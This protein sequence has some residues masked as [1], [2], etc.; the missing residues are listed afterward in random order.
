MDLFNSADQYEGAIVSIQ[1]DEV[2]LEGEVVPQ[3]DGP[4]STPSMHG[5]VQS[6]NFPHRSPHNYYLS[7]LVPP[8]LSVILDSTETNRESDQSSEIILRLNSLLGTISVSKIDTYNDLLEI[9]AYHGP[10]SRR[11]A[12]S[13]MAKFWPKAAGHTS[14]S[15]PFCAPLQ[16]H[17][18]LSKHSHLHQFVPWHFNFNEDR[19]HL[20][21]MSH[22]NCR[23]CTNPLRGF[24]LICPF[25]MCAVHFDCYDYPEGNYQI[26]YSMAT[27]PTVQ[28][29]AMYRFSDLGTDILTG[30]TATSEN[31]DFRPVNW[32]TLC[33]CYA[34]QTPLWGWIAQGLRCR[35]CSVAVHM[36]CLDS[37]KHSHPCE[38]IIF[39]SMHMTI[40]WENLRNSCLAHF[41][42]L[43]GFTRDELDGCSRE[44]ISIYHA[45]FCTQ[46]QLLS[47][48]IAMGSI[49]VTEKGTDSLYNPSYEVTKFEL[50]QFTNWCDQLLLN[51]LPCSLLTQQFLR[52]N[53]VHRLD[54]SLMHEW[55]YLE[56]ISSNLKMSLPQGQNTHT[57]SEFLNINQVMNA[58]NYAIAYSY[59]CI[60]LPHMRDILR[61]HFAIQSDHAAKFILDHLHHLSFFDRVDRELG[62]FNDLSHENEVRCIFPLPFG[63]DIST[64]VESLVSSVEACLTDLDLSSNEFGFLLLTR[65]LWPNR[66]ASEYGLK[67]LAGRVLGWILKEVGLSPTLNCIS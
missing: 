57:A 48:G 40:T 41:S 4:L 18:Q 55:S 54:H 25:C 14:I 49:I 23:S 27:D 22:M 21:V 44:E 59:E 47:N 19:F 20:N 29:L 63:L 64:N 46:L 42:P 5:G 56:Y 34:C 30:P 31:H 28:R 45:I 37:L 67:R 65:R 38:T 60:S 36:A 1:I 35:L 3:Q 32:L 12:I 16:S 15:S 7:F 8:L 11:L 50:S 61:T 10:K 26:Q 66:L 33:L 51:K 6:S 13:F 9:I 39:T 2:R 53:I 62:P 24:A 58:D 17:F 52:N 43:L